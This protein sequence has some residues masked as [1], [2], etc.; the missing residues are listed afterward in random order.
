MDVHQVAIN[1]SNLGADRDSS[2]FEQA[3]TQLRRRFTHA[4]PHSAQYGQRLLVFEREQDDS[5]QCKEDKRLRQPRTPCR[6]GNGGELCRKPGNGKADEQRQRGY[7]KK[8]AG[9]KIHVPPRLTEQEAEA[10]Q[11]HRVDG[12]RYAVNAQTIAEQQDTAYHDG[13]LNQAGA[14]DLLRLA[15]GDE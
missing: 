7:G 1:H 14:D 5:V 2:L 11:E 10:D 13:E 4:S 9:A 6:P 3:G 8:P 15:D 12:K